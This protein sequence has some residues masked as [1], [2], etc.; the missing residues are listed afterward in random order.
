MLTIYD[1]ISNLEKYLIE[2]NL[3]DEPYLSDKDR[4]L[5]L[6][7][8]VIDNN[9]LDPDD[10]III[11][12]ISFK[13][14]I[15]KLNSLSDVSL[16]MLKLTKQILVASERHIKLLNEDLSE[17]TSNFFKLGRELNS[18]IEETVDELDKIK[19]EDTRIYPSPS[20]DFLITEFLDEFDLVDADDILYKFK[21]QE[22]DQYLDFEY[23]RITGDITYIPYKD[24]CHIGFYIIN[25]N[26]EFI[27][28][29]N[30][31]DD[32]DYS[33]YYMIC[34]RYP[35]LLKRDS[36]REIEAHEQITKT[37]IMNTFR[38]PSTK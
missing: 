23:Y 11:S 25:P 37:R 24:S 28:I 27:P 10:N 13:E 15:E 26:V 21:Y 19:T 3:N 2:F 32:K 8:S 36:F 6:L 12:S 5:V 22:D 38:F 14:Q 29:E 9:L 1:L 7:N 4:F 34:L 30:C 31:L 16:L 35:V 20:K 18:K 17:L 33:E